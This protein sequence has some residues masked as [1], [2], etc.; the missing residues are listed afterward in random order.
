MKILIPILG[1]DRT[2]GY[3]VLS[4]LA[5]AWV[6]QGCTVDF[7]SPATSAPPYFPT[8]AGILW[9]GN[10][11]QVSRTQPEFP[12]RITGFDNL[13]KIYQGCRAIGGEYDVILAN[14]SLTT[15]PIWLAQ[16]KHSNLV[17]YVQAYEPDYYRDER[18]PLKWLLSFLSYE[19]PFS[20]IVNSPIYAYLWRG[21]ASRGAGVVPFGIDLDIFHAK[22]AA[23]VG[24]SGDFVIGCIG[25]REPSKGTRYVLEAFEALAAADDSVRLRVAYGNLPDGWSHPRA[26]IVVPSNDRELADFYRSVDVLVAPGLLQHGA[27]HYPVLEGMACGVPVVNTFYIPANHGNSWIVPPRDPGAI[28][29]AVRQIRSDPARQDR[30]ELAIGDAKAFEWTVVAGRMLELFRTH[31]DIRPEDLPTA[32]KD[33]PAWAD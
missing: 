33:L 8:A 22:P 25:R 6:R 3:R 19:L 26:E 27:P 32:P 30:I 18:Q 21:I 23:G 12:G 5:G 17:Y 2:G 1:F 13:R 7:L 20:I 14:H 11:G 28:A 31:R 9:V 29:E 10:I 16:P 15:W 24:G 4:E